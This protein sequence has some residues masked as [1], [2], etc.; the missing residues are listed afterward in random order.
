M[1]FK[2]VIFDLDGTLVCTLPEYRY[3]IVGKTLADLGA[4]A[5][6]HDIDRFWFESR[7]NELIRTLFGV[8]PG[9][10]WNIFRMYDAPELRKQ[11]TRP[12]DDVSFLPEL[13]RHGCKTGIVTG[14][15]VSIASLEI[16]MLGKDLFDAIVIA[17]ASNGIQP[18]PHPHGLEECLN[19]L[20]VE[21]DRALYIGNADEDILTAR[22]AHVFDVFLARGEH[23][24]PDVTPS[25]RI[26]S[27]FELRDI[28][29][30]SHDTT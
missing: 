24:F 15:P 23:E 10:F 12:Y 16:E 17:Q 3:R 2:A 4:T 18:K 29:G 28:L 26:R 7:R 6:P 8:D 5:T 25:L 27:L 30:I 14:S 19:L 13:R 1:K 9:A 20:A 21:H 22:N 11:F